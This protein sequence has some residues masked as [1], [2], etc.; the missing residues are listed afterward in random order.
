MGN[1]I[2]TG[3]AGFIGSHLA[4]SL[5]EQGAKVIGIDQINNYYDPQLKHNNIA[6]LKRYPNFKFIKANIQDLDW[7]HPSNSRSSKTSKKPQ[8]NCLCF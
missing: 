2:V 7:C 3:V 8:A 5:L 6:S 1:I 4:E